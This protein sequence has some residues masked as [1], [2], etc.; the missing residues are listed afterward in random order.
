MEKTTTSFAK[1]KGRSEN[2]VDRPNQSGEVLDLE[3]NDW[4]PHAPTAKA[5]IFSDPSRN[6]RFHEGAERDGHDL[7]LDPQD[8]AIREKTVYGVA[9]L[10]QMDR[11]KSGKDEEAYDADA[12]R[13]IESE[14]EQ[15]IAKFFQSKVPVV[16]MCNDRGRDYTDNVKEDYALDLDV[17]LEQVKGGVSISHVNMAKQLSREVGE[18]AKVHEEELD[19]APKYEASS[20]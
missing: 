12:A 1:M 19:L 18:A 16:D 11:F 4:K 2:L 7:I 6:P 8:N 5:V 17:K 20:K 10:K 3:V 15:N 9:M 14:R 13:M